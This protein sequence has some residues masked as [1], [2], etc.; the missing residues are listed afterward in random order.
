[1]DATIRL[2]FLRARPL[3]VHS[4]IG[5]GVAVNFTRISMSSFFVVLY[6][7]NVS[8]LILGDV[9]ITETNLINVIEKKFQFFKILGD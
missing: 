3:T 4:S 5:G 8:G 2:D 7:F 6:I 9:S 1:M